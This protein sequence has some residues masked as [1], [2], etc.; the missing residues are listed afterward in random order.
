MLLNNNRQNE[1]YRNKLISRVLLQ[2]VVTILQM[3]LY[4]GVYICL[5]R[6]TANCKHS[7]LNEI[8]TK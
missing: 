7:K 4:L 2:H 3:T 8:E 6:S 1:N 5:Q